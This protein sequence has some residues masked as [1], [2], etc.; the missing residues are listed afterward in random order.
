MGVHRIK[1][2]S[3]CSSDS[4]KRMIAEL[5][6]K[7]NKSNQELEN[8]IKA[9][10]DKYNL[11]IPKMNLT[12]TFSFSESL[13]VKAFDPNGNLKTHLIVNDGKEELMNY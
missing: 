13:D 6:A 1:D 2:D 3:V 8:Y 4:H 5:N 10:E 12:Q 11:E 9:L 7:I